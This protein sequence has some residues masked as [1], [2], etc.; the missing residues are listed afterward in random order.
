MQRPDDALSER[1]HVLRARLESHF[2]ADTAAAAGSRSA[3][4][5]GHCA[6]VA[7]IVHAMFGGDYVSATVRGTSH[8]FNRVGGPLGPLWIDL[9]GD[10]FGRDCVQ[11]T[12]EPP[13]DTTHVRA[14]NE[15]MPETLER[16]RLLASRAGLADVVV[17]IS[18]AISESASLRS[19]ATDA[20]ERRGP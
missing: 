5:A 10:Q 8:W 9:T 4:S 12:L 16:A 19:D 2:A 13:Y 18:A 7:V 15:L 3:P 1:L 14:E 11:L 20:Q 6:A 17:A